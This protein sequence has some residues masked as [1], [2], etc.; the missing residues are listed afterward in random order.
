LLEPS[1]L[2]RRKGARIENDVA[3]KL[4]L[5]GIPVRKRS[6]MYVPGHDIDITVRGRTLRDEVKARAGFRTIYNRLND[7]DVLI[8]DRKPA[9]VVLPPGLGRTAPLNT[10]KTAFN[11]ELAFRLG[12]S[13]R[14]DI[15]HSDQT[16]VT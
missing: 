16:R 11:G 9:L 8:A 7:R 10:M 14:A 3:H 1:N 6:G 13:H 5:H 15:S 2:S 4:N 12:L